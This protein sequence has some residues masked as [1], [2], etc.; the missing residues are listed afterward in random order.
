[1]FK[2]YRPVGWRCS[3]SCSA[4]VSRQSGGKG[5]F[6]HSSFFSRS[7]ASADANHHVRRGRR[8]FSSSKCI[9]SRRHY[10]NTILTHNRMSGEA[11]KLLS[12]WKPFRRNSRQPFAAAAG[13]SLS[14]TSKP[15]E[16]SFIKSDCARLDILSRRGQ[17]RGKNGGKEGGGGKRLVCCNHAVL[18]LELFSREFRALCRAL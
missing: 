5:P 9:S 11:K 12:P 18:G 2:S 17:E 1:M 10:R 4:S 15:A 14:S 3:C 7:S 6:R 13:F 8:H 16:I